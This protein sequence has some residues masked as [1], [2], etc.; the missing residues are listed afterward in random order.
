MTR[1][2]V[3]TL[4]SDRPGIVAAVTDALAEHGANLE[5]CAMSQLGG[6]F[7]MVL[8]VSAEADRAPA[9]EAH[10]RSATA[11][12]DLDVHVR[13]IAA[14]TEH[15]QTTHLVSAYGADRQGIVRDVSGWLAG[16][17]INIRDLETRVLPSDPPTYALLAEV[18]LP[19]EVS[20]E[21]LATAFSEAGARWGVTA[22]LRAVDSDVF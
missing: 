15:S 11:A 4:G 10:L 18:S 3:F 17:G 16:H 7:A 1:W 5:D 12:F 2:V 8:V 22:Q 13:P 14:G 20:A 9:L 21:A 6:Q 19:G